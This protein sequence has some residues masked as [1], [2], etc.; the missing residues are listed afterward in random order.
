MVGGV[1][2]FGA[3]GYHNTPIDE[4]LPLEASVG[5]PAFVEEEL[6]PSLVP[7][8]SAH[9]IVELAP[10]AAENAA[11]WRRLAPLIGA[12]LLGAP[13]RGAQVLLTHPAQKLPSGAAMP[14]LAVGPAGK[15]RVLALGVDSTFRWGHTTAGVTGDASGYERFWDRALRWLS[16]DP[17]LDP[18]RIET[19]RERYGPGSTLEAKMMLRDADYRVVADRAVEIAVVD[20]S[21]ATRQVARVQTDAQGV[22]SAKLVVPSDPGG[23]RLLARE[24]A[25]PS[26]GLLAE[27]GFIVEEGGDELADPRPQAALLEKL[28]RD[29][30]GRFFA[31]D[32]A[33]ELDK[34]E[35]T[36]GR[37]LGSSVRAPFGSPWALAALITLFALE[38]ALRRLW[39]LR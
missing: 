10:D 25:K 17:R 2:S 33:L 7:A 22:A 37:A 1:R 23:Y 34:L 28:A 15:G 32:Q 11:A 21:G 3:G 19:D 18:A 4:I 5:T 6:V 24:A 13:R 9:P 36:R 26:D 16:R 20:N 14:L 31:A 29:T 12:N 30:G 39:G 35:R 8:T 27:E 38:W